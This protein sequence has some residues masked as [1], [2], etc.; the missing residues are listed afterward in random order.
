VRFAADALETAGSETAPLVTVKFQYLRHLG[1]G[2]AAGN[3]SSSS[4]G[5]SGQHKRAV[6]K[7]SVRTRRHKAG[8]LVVAK[9]KPDQQWQVDTVTFV[10]VVTVILVTLVTVTVDTCVL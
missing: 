3:S 7:V 6:S 1:H 8:D 4:T 9:V 10:T 5:S 2:T